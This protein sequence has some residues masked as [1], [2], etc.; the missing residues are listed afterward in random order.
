MCFRKSRR[1]PRAQA[2][3]KEISAFVSQINRLS[4]FRFE[5]RFEAKYYMSDGFRLYSIMNS[6]RNT[7]KLQYS[8]LVNTKVLKNSNVMLALKTY[9]HNNL[10][11]E[12]FATQHKHSAMRKQNHCPLINVIKM[13]IIKRKQVRGFE[14]TLRFTCTSDVFS[15]RFGIKHQPP[16]NMPYNMLR[17]RDELHRKGRT[18]TAL[19]HVR[20]MA[21]S[22]LIAIASLAEY[23]I[24]IYGALFEGPPQW[25][26][27]Q[28]SHPHGRYA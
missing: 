25:H 10:N 12:K 6:H 15:Q 4:A 22:D 28:A 16:S 14:F 19:D 2:R 23:A 17:L 20:I 27:L 8:R 18:G 9:E 21:S 1:N 24:F 13:S 26:F 5:A 3:P 11:I 7:N